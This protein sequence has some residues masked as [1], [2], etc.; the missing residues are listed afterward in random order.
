V[1]KK[2]QEKRIPPSKMANSN[3]GL[4]FTSN[5]VRNSKQEI[6]WINVQLTCPS[7]RKEWMKKYWK[8]QYRS[9]ILFLNPWDKKKVQG[10]RAVSP[11]VRRRV[12]ILILGYLSNIM[13]STNTEIKIA[14]IPVP[15]TTVF[16][17]DEMFSSGIFSSRPIFISEQADQE[18]C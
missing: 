12:I 8:L 11:F 15:S 4:N 1:L 10:K 6:K 14:V 13:P 7:L 9:K 18:R 17:P 3:F 16:K 2:I 5:S